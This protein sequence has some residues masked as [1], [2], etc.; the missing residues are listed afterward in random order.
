M[1]VLGG[2]GN[3]TELKEI[4]TYFD[5][6]DEER[7][8]SVISTMMPDESV[9]KCVYCNHRCPFKVAQMERMDEIKNY[10]GQ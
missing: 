8:Y 4:L 9:G 6:T 5:R 3:V 7:D 2:P 10:F 1:T